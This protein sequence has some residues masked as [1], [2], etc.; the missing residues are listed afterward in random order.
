MLLGPSPPFQN[1]QRP[2]PGAQTLSQIPVGGDSKG[3]QMPRICP[4]SPL[5][6]N[7]DRCMGP[8]VWER[9]G[10]RPSLSQKPTK[11]EP[12]S[13]LGLESELWSSNALVNMPFN[14]STL[15]RES[16]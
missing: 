6:L 16:F 2:H 4:R 7:I 11:T 9:L 10:R 15:S 1:S 12:G 5:G 14:K 8:A 3:N 13:V